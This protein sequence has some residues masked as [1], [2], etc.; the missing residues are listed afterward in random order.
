MYQYL[1][2]KEYMKNPPI[3]G[4]VLVFDEFQNEYISKAIESAQNKDLI[5]VLDWD[6][7]YYQIFKDKENV[8]Y[9]NPQFNNSSISI[10][11]C[12][13]WVI[14]GEIDEEM[15]DS[16]ANLFFLEGYES[17]IL[18]ALT[19]Y[20]LDN[21][22][23]INFKSLLEIDISKVHNKYL[24]EIHFST[25][26]SMISNIKQFNKDFIISNSK[27]SKLKSGTILFL[28]S[29][30]PFD[31]NINSYITENLIID[32]YKNNKNVLF[33]IPCLH[34]PDVSINHLNE[35]LLNSRYNN[36]QYIIISD[37][38]HLD[39]QG[40]LQAINQNIDYITGKS[41]RYGENYLIAQA[42]NK[43][44]TKNISPLLEFW[45]TTIISML[46]IFFITKLPYIRNLCDVSITLVD[47]P[48]QVKPV[49]I[50]QLLVFVTGC[51]TLPKF[52]Y[53]KS[54]GFLNTILLVSI[55]ILIIIAITYLAGR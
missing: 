4:N 12:K 8:V 28:N 2:K 14:N 23:P 42:I 17:L 52:Q 35:I 27:Q 18:K 36:S 32:N 51:V 46:S 6:G 37:L 49:T 19:Q 20:A 38:R 16:F 48:F 44:S 33:I 47:S 31:L 41:D 11:V 45:I 9:F 1:T 53:I 5:V 39:R 7:Y 22:I 29:A 54:N 26:N 15:I 13:H 34:C 50:S 55:Q 43:S 21:D 30:C 10:D 3:N 24:D 40:I 25:H